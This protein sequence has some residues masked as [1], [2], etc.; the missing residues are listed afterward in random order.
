MT[1]FQPRDPQ[2]QAR[3]RASFDGQ[4]ALH[5]L[6]ASLE[7]IE[8]GVVGIRLE[9]RD[10]LSGPG[11]PVH[12]GI[13]ATVLAS[14]CEFAALSLSRPGST[15]VPVEHKVNFV[16]VD[17]AGPLVAYG[18]VVRSGGTITVC[19]GRICAEGVEKKAVAH[20]LA[21]FI[22]ESLPLDR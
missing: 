3:V 4:V 1:N 11:G 18:E 2:F 12:P 5:T 10:T 20:M 19:K 16:A 9:C 6:G 14:A 21:T 22:T 15:I 13:A 8:P 17:Q 7:S